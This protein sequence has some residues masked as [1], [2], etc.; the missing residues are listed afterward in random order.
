MSALSLLMEKEKFSEVPEEF[1]ALY[2]ERDG[3]MVLDPKGVVPKSTLHEYMDNNR[4]LHRKLQE[5]QERFKDLDP[6][7]ARKALAEQQKFKDKKLLDESKA[8]ELIAERTGQLRADYEKRLQELTG[9]NQ[10]L[11]AR[12]SEVLVDKELLEAAAKSGLREEAFEDALL[13]G[14]SV[15]RVVDGKVIPLQEE[16]IL[17]GKDRKT[18]LSMKEWLEEKVASKPHW[19]KA[20]T[21]GTAQPKGTFSANGGPPNKKRAEMSLSEKSALI[22]KIGYDAY[23]KLP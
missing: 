7:E 8:E 5:T 22:G 15:F 2:T 11:S 3:Q 1:R 17:Y 6:E 9:S 21:G 4:T 18:P 19:F 23:M 16:K 20:T 12:L 13:A 14:R 10:T